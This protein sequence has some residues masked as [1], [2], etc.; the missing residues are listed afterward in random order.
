MTDFAGEN[1]DGAQFHDVSLVGAE[2]RKADLSRATFR[3]VDFTGVLI[4]GVYA[5]TMEIDGA[6]ENLTVNGIDVMP[7]V[8]AELDRRYPDRPK[9]RPTDAAGF[10]EAWDVLEGLWEQTVSRARGFAPE[11][12]HERVDGSGPSSRRCG[13]SSSPPTRG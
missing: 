3:N 7:L 10:R 6:I 11:L 8:E 9:M 13:I 12:L 1:L 5:T 2:F 4:R